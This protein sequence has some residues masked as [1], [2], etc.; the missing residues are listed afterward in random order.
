LDLAAAPA[1]REQSFFDESLTQLDIAIAGPDFLQ[2]LLGQV[3]DLDA[4]ERAEVHLA[5][6]RH[7]RVQERV[8]TASIEMRAGGVVAVEHGRADLRSHVEADV[9]RAAL[10]DERGD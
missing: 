2:R 6:E 8:E 3:A 7:P 1:H 5:A 4:N 10:L 9:A